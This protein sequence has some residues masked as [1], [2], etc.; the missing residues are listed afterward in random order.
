MADGFYLTLLVGPVVP[1]PAPPA[2]VDA[3]TSAQVTVS[4][5]QRSGFQLTFAVSKRSSIQEHLLPAGFFDP[6]TRVVL[7]VVVNGLPEVLIDGVITRQDLSA[8]DT[9]G[10]STLNV[11][12]EDVSVMMS[13]KQEQLGWPFPVEARVALIVAKYFRYGMIP[14]VVPMPLPDV[15]VP[16]AE[17][18]Q[19]AATDL[20][21]V[22]QLADDTGYVFYVEPGPVPGVN[23]AYWGPEVRIGIPQPALSVDMD[24]AG[25]VESMTFGFDGLSREQVTIVV[26]EPTTKI[27]IPIPLPDVSILR[28]PLALRQAPSLRT[29]PIRDVAKLKPTR[30]ALVGLSRAAQ[31]SD[32]VTGSGQLDVLRYGRPLKARRLVGVRGAGIAYDGLYYVRSVTHTIK[33]GEYKQSFSL[34]RNGLVPLTPAVVP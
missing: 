20:D 28:P 19:Q 11:T 4:A 12:G 24:A 34:T 29:R 22:T 23:I 30:A 33:R 7:M 1:V 15:P 17:I 16:T 3:L 25:N 21:Y 10:R 2:L 32:A 8:S 6:G 9:P 5:G 13:L 26:Q 27:G 14:L 31:S 18:P